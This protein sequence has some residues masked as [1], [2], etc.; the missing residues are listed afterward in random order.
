MSPGQ[1]DDVTGTKA[2]PSGRR[3]RG[4]RIT[5][6]SLASAA[7]LLGAAAAGTYIYVNHEV[8][9]IPRV[10]VKF[11]AQDDSSGGMTILLTDSQV[12]PTGLR[13]TPQVRR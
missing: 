11:L 10:P 3:R 5:L 2:A 8:G 12:G 1:G 6:V 7:V 4:L 13:G 9:N